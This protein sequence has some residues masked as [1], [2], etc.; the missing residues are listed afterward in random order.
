TQGGNVFIL[1]NN[2][3]AGCSFKTVQEIQKL[4]GLPVVVIGDDPRNEPAPA[5]P[6]TP[7]TADSVAAG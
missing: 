5:T 1:L 6:A 4:F 7:A 3:Y 2:H